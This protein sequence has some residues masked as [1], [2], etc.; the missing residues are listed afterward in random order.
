L[1]RTEDFVAYWHEK[2]R[3]QIESGRSRR[4]GLLATQAI[5]SADNRAVLRRILGSGAIFFARSSE[6]WVLQGANVAISFVGQ[7]DGTEHERDLDGQGVQSINADLS[8]GVD[9]TRAR[10]LTENLGIAFQGPV[11]VG[12]F[13]ISADRAARFLA[14][15][16]PHG[17]SNADV[18]RPWLNGSDLTT[19]PRGLFI[20]DFG[21]MT[22]SDAAL[23]EAPFE[24][25]REHIRP[26]RE[27]GRR[28]RR[29]ERWWLH[30]ETVPGLR[31]A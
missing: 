17:R 27:A 19:R 16:N 1:P 25:V 30:G 31:R 11:K 4:A 20:I 6:P 13:E 3:A 26:M 14:S 18:V 23:Y 12:P 21:E 10:S 9:L 8:T 24:Y 22:A 29:A 2:A 5:R 28:R 15:P 7:D